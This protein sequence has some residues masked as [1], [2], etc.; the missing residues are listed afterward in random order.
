MI[1]LVS[2]VL[3]LLTCP[4]VSNVPTGAIDPSWGFA[5]HA[6]FSG[7]AGHVPVT[8]FTYGPLGFLTVPVL[9]GTWTY[10]LALV[11]VLGVQVVLCRLLLARI[12]AVAPWWVALIGTFVMAALVDVYVAET[13]L[14]TVALLA[15]HLL[16]NGVQEERR[17]L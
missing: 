8:S 6:W 13:F 2:L 17:W 16:Q 3:G 7:S 15:A 4:L 10:L 11:F 14:V 5:M 9:W 1:W 12:N